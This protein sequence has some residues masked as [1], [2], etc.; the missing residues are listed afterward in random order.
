MGGSDG[1]NPFYS[2]LIHDKA[3]NFYGTTE[4]GGSAGAGTIFKFAPGQGETVLYSFKS[5]NDGGYPVATLFLDKA[6]NLYG[7]TNGGGAGDF[8]TVFKLAPNGT[9]TV[10]YSFQGG[11]DGAY[12]LSSLFED[13]SG[14]LYGTTGGGDVGN[15]FG[16]VFKLAPNGTETVLY[17]FTGGSDGSQPQGGLIANSTDQKGALFG[18]TAYGGANGYGTV[19]SVKKQRL[20]TGSFHDAI[21]LGKLPVPA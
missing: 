3:G 6:G 7:T 18:T 11:S 1:K 10:L 9:E 17:A 15:D 16:T 2:G 19:F 13:A 12:P 4:E 21:S 14:N 8:G 5:G 20:M